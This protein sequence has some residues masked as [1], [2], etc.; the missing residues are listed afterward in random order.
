VA[1]HLKRL[2]LA[3]LSELEPREPARRY[4]RQA[5]RELVHFDTNLG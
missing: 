3:L 5:P 1:K 2:G 4:Q